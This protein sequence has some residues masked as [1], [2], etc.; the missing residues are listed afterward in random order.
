M[1]TPFAERMWLS[2][3]ALN[4]SA[5]A[6]HQQGSDVCIAMFAD[7]VDTVV[8][9]VECYPG[10]NL[11]QAASRRPKRNAEPS[12]MAATVVVAPSSPIP[13]IFFGYVS[14]SDLL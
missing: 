11:S 13:E 3:Q 5:F 7:F 2:I 1:P 9:P 6:V 14:S 10:T 4:H 8:P 12:L